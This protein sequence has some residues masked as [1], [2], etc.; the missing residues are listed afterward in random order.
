VKR[1][2]ARK[3]DEIDV[4]PEDVVAEPAPP[5]DEYDASFDRLRTG[6]T[7]AVSHELRTPLARILALL[8]SAELPDADVPSLIDQAR[9][10]VEHAGAL[11]DEILFLSELESGKEVV[12][13]G[14]TTALPIL[15]TVVSSLESTAARAGVDVR[16]EGDPSV[17]LP[18]RPRM[19]HMVAENVTENAIRYAGHG[20]RFTLAVRREGDD[21]VLSA[22][23]DGIGVSESDLPRIFERFYRADRARASRGTGLGLAIVKHV[24]T[25][26]GGTVEA[27]GE[28]AAGLEVRCV[29]P[30][31]PE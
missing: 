2:F 29:F 9:A 20:A 26:A 22:A 31:T 19:L 7:A 18:L 17:D 16:V 28:R 21:A 30:T 8:D 4:E 23:D 6:F 13:L 11:I 25:A 12:A 24:V 5:Q 1:L 27:R 15:Q 10:E 3:Q 14:R